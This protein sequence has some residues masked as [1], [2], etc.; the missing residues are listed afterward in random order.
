[1]QKKK[2]FV[3]HNS[4]CLIISVILNEIHRIVI[5]EILTQD[6]GGPTYG[7][8]GQMNVRKEQLYNI[9]LPL[10]GEHTITNYEHKQIVYQS[11]TWSNTKFQESP[12]N[13]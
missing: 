10:R 2:S 8:Y 9:C 4:S 7:Q 13:K 12:L 3:Y 5:E 11:L 1:M 6:I